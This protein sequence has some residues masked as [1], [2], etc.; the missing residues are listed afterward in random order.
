[1]NIDGRTLKVRE[2]PKLGV[3]VEDL[4]ELVVHDHLE[5]EKKMIQ[6]YPLSR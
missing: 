1:M 2:H 3:Y 5:I 6:V 4:V